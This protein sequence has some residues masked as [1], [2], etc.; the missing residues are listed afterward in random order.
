[1]STVDAMHLYGKINITVL[2]DS[3]GEKVSK[4]MMR[5]KK[6][7]IPLMNRY[8]TFNEESD[9]RGYMFVE[10]CAVS[11]CTLYFKS[12]NK[13]GRFTQVKSLFHTTLLL[14]QLKESGRWREK[15]WYQIWFVTS[16]A[17]CNRK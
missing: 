3:R 6:S 17:I 7:C 16:N 14:N 4:C 8:S 1:M 13:L 10:R 12:K 15:N 11:S 9:I 2:N 5:E